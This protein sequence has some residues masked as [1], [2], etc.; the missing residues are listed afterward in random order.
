MSTP[1]VTKQRMYVAVMTVASPLVHPDVF[2]VVSVLVVVVVRLSVHE[3]SAVRMRPLRNVN[4][5]TCK[6][7]DEMNGRDALL[8]FIAQ[9]VDRRSTKNEMVC[10]RMRRMVERMQPARAEL[11]CADEI[12]DDVLW[13]LAPARLENVRMSIT[14]VATAVAVERTH[15]IHSNLRGFCMVACVI[16]CLNE[17]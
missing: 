3:A 6:K 15:D 9:V 12:V 16:G 1:V 13:F 8:R 7:E 10:R 5:A 2:V 17:I 11:N 14:I 4:K